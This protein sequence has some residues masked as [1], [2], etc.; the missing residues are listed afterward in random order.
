M[1]ISMIT[2]KKYILKACDKQNLSKFLVTLNDFF[3]KGFT[4][5]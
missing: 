5:S 3:E 1:I 4:I 2:I